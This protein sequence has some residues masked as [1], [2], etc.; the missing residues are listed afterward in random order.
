VPLVNRILFFQF[1]AGFGKRLGGLRPSI[2]QV[3]YGAQFAQT[4]ACFFVARLD[5]NT[6]LNYVA[7]RIFGDII[8]PYGGV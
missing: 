3:A 4:R 8:P 6:P 2:A 7:K 5:G 1:L